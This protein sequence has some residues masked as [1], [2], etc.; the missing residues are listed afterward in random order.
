MFNFTTSHLLISWTSK[1]IHCEITTDNHYLIPRESDNL[2]VVD[3]LNT[4]LYS[5]LCTRKAL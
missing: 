2:C 1:E 5:V 3:H 4:R